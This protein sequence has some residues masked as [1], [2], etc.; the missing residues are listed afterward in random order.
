LQDFG[1]L[2]I[3]FDHYCQYLPERTFIREETGGGIMIVVKNVSNRLVTVRLN[4]G[5]SLILDPGRSSAK[6]VEQEVKDN[7]KIDKLISLGIINLEKPA[8]EEISP[9]EFNENTGDVPS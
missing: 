7:A 1:V 8:A 9:E 5:D 6:M 4:S 2:P 3:F